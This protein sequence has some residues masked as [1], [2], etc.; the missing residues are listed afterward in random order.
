MNAFE[1]VIFMEHETIIGGFKCLYWLVKNEISHH[2]N[3]SKLL[4]P[5]SSAVGSRNNYHS[6]R[7]IDEMIEEP[8]VA[9][10]SVPSHQP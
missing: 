10:M 6:Y 4:W 2:T 7:I 1:P 5:S 3:Y 8:L 9:E